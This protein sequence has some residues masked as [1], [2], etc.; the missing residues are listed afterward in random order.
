MILTMEEA[1][2]GDCFEMLFLTGTTTFIVRST[3]VAHIGCNV[4]Y[5]SLE[6]LGSTFLHG[7]ARADPEPPR[8]SSGMVL[9]F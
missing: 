7:S 2:N 3:G 1:V 9:P 5:D 4:C 6:S 8:E